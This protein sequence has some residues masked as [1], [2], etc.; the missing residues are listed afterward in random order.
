MKKFAF[1]FFTFMMASMGLYAQTV[2]L[3]TALQKSSDYLDKSLP[4]GSTVFVVNIEADSK[5]LANYISD[6]L[7]TY[8]VNNRNFTVVDRQ[9]I[10]LIEQELA[11][12]MSGEVSDESA[13]SIGKKIGAQ[14]IIVGSIKPE[15]NGY[16]L[17]I[18][19][20]SV[21]T[22]VVQGLQ[23]YDI[24]LD[25]R[26]SALINGDSVKPVEEL[27]KYKWFYFGLRAGGS[28][29]SY[30][31]VDSSD[32]ALTFINPA[33]SYSFNAA[34]SASVQITNWFGAG[35][36]FIYTH[37]EAKV[38]TTGGGVVET[39]DGGNIST[40]NDPRYSSG[41]F[42]YNSFMIPLL[43]KFTVRP[44]KFV[45]SGFIG[46]YL[47]ISFGEL[48][49]DGTLQAGE[50]KGIFKPSSTN[51]GIMVGGDVGYHLGPGALFVDVRYAKDLANHQ[52][53]PS[54]GSWG[55]WNDYSTKWR[56]MP[57][58]EISRSK[59]LFTIGY[60]IGLFNK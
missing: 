21:E 9:N 57:D 27:W 15:I 11:Y 35:V 42:S 1:A 51:Y 37:D 24:K 46:P 44:K 36:E 8:L 18:R 4:R 54:E 2:D 25:K 59:V 30:D 14:I 28:Y 38:N 47:G 26:L 5:T 20:L 19:A 6:E 48:Q 41:T 40:S 12:Q 39:T 60:E 50:W 22:A 3:D 17:N 55:M 13:Q 10:T 32:S 31:E 23:R 43:A 52:F 45:F 29:N 7:S 56:F 34:F 58:M 49:F 33:A 16:R 53:E